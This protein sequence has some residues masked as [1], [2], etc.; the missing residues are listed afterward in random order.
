MILPTRPLLYPDLKRQTS[1]QCP[2]F[3]FFCAADFY[4]WYHGQM[5]RIQ[6]EEFLSKQKDG[7]F[8]IRDSESTAGDF[9]LSVK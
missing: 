9:T 5:N 2:G 1:Y 7:S 8:I 4:R 3:I 6:A